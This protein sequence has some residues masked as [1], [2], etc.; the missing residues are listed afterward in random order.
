MSKDKK[1]YSDVST[2]QNLKHDII[3]EEYPE[4][5]YGSPYGEME[6][7]KGKSTPWKEDQKSISPF[8]YSQKDLH[9]HTPRQTPGAH[10]VPE[11]DDSD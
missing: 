11:E 2:V 10:R 5:P 7:V 8:A 9:E 6:P 3:P 4:G 1:K